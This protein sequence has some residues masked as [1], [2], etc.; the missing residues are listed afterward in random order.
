MLPEEHRE[1]E[2]KQQPSAT[3]WGSGWV[4]LRV[5]QESGKE[6]LFFPLEGQVTL[7]FLWRD[8]SRKER[9]TSVCSLW[10]VFANQKGQAVLL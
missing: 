4:G 2:K 3:P 6:E 10:L 1:K 9:N 5:Q 7:C 8:Y